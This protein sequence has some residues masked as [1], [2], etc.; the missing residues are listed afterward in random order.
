MLYIILLYVYKAY[1]KIFMVVSVDDNVDY[2][3]F[4]KFFFIILV[5][6]FQLLQEK[7]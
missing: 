5:Y 6:I 7:L 2:G 1:R 4:K 3:W